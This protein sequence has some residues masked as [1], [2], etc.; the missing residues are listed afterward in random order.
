MITHIKQEFISDIIEENTSN[1]TD[2]N[3][4]DQLIDN[5]DNQVHILDSPSNYKSNSDQLSENIE[6]EIIKPNDSIHIANDTNEH[7]ESIT[8]NGSTDISEN[9]GSSSNKKVTENIAKEKNY[10]FHNINIP[11]QF[12]SQ[13]SNSDSYMHYKFNDNR[14]QFHNQ[15]PSDLKVI[16]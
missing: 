15:F 1:A 7:N 3:I 11:Q 12:I 16:C 2:N 14:I 6:N 4:I 10:T 13:S 8:N 9:T 5:N